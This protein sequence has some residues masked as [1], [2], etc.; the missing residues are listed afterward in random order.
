MNSQK[1]KKEKEYWTSNATSSVLSPDMHIQDTCA[2]F[3]PLRKQRTKQHFQKWMWLMIMGMGH[4]HLLGSFW[5]FSMMD[6][7]Y[8]LVSSFLAGSME[9]WVSCLLHTAPSQGP[10]SWGFRRLGGVSGRRAGV[11]SVPP[12][13]E[14]HLCLWVCAFWV[15]ASERQM[16]VGCPCD[17]DC[18]SLGLPMVPDWN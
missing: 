15:G 3:C 14:H 6:T 11:L 9:P 8:Y 7:G 5:D 18:I 17:S 1:Y 10:R 12:E 16:R 2:Y 13:A 4:A